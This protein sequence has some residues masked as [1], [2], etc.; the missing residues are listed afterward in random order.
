MHETK[1]VNQFIKSS[2]IGVSELHAHIDEMAMENEQTNHYYKKRCYSPAQH[3][4]VET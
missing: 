2:L 3:S 1:S 4:S